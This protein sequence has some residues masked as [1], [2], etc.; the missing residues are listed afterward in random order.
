MQ[1]QS[2]RPS[3]D[4]WTPVVKREHSSTAEEI[5]KKL[6]D[7][8][9]SRKE[10]LKWHEE[11]AIQDEM[12]NWQLF[13]K[14]IFTDAL[15]R[16]I[17]QEVVT[18]EPLDATM[19]D[20][21]L[22]VIQKACE[23]SYGETL[24]A[25]RVEEK[26]EFAKYAIKKLIENTFPLHKKELPKSLF[27]YIE[28]KLW[29]AICHD[30]DCLQR[31]ECLVRPGQDA[32]VDNSN[33][34]SICM[35]MA[36]SILEDY[37]QVKS[38]RAD[39]N[40]KYHINLMATMREEMRNKAEEEASECLFLD[41]EDDVED[42]IQSNIEQRQMV[43]G[44]AF[45]KK[46]VKMI[47]KEREEVEAK[48]KNDPNKP[49]LVNRENYL[50]KEVLAGWGEPY[51]RSLE[52]WHS[53]LIRMEMPW[54]IKEMIDIAKDDK[55]TDLGDYLRSCIK[56]AKKLKKR[57]AV[58]FGIRKYYNIGKLVQNPH[59]L[60]K[61]IQKQLPLKKDNFTRRKYEWTLSKTYASCEE[62][63]GKCYLEMVKAALRGGFSS[64]IGNKKNIT[65]FKPNFFH[66][67][68][69]E[70][71]KRYNH[72]DP[73]E[74]LTYASEQLDKIGE[75]IKF[76]FQSA[77]P[78]PERV[79]IKEDALTRFW[80]QV[81]RILI[82]TDESK[83]ELDGYLSKRNLQE[84][85]IAQLESLF[86][87]NHFIP[88]IIPAVGKSDYWQVCWVH[89]LGVQVRF[90]IYL[91]EASTNMECTFGYWREDPIYRNEHG[92]AKGLWGR[93]KNMRIQNRKNELYKRCLG[94]II[95]ASFNATAWTNHD[96]LE[97]KDFLS[98]AHHTCNAKRYYH[99]IDVLTRNGKEMCHEKDKEQ[100]NNDYPSRFAVA[101]GDQ[102]FK[103]VYK[104][105]GYA[106]L[107]DRKD[108][109]FAALLKERYFLPVSVQGMFSN[110]D[111]RQSA[112]EHQHRP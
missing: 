75:I 74:E 36:Q 45:S 10:A 52:A 79:S 104:K 11:S 68:L 91:K 17:V 94:V 54:K 109:R 7:L 59:K 101:P 20:N 39:E 110:P 98:I 77:L 4:G 103:P 28:D 22:P 99:K 18:V 33:L 50:E 93:S 13:L 73:E 23:D 26:A 112:Q 97:E 19:R 16:G 46:V 84:K 30:S 6:K 70:E 15:Q 89:H 58:L 38:E 29:A 62:Y 57:H 37:K 56:S 9:N 49:S 67:H 65:I 12:N 106:A 96:K 83:Q 48:I 51:D 78:E 61:L 95:P 86:V 76:Y 53:Y 100:F 34:E 90:K 31:V 72:W 87:E 25:T 35:H 81:D 21:I 55:T 32:V 85:H 105:D 88:L 40:L 64:V 24:A 82:Q 41:D 42:S 8:E 69:I 27:G 108:G 102:T 66:L 47:L 44:A 111:A 5:S 3:D 80:R 60:K 43:V 92:I 71:L 1:R 63:E 14:S 2:N 107:L